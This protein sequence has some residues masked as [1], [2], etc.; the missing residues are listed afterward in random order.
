MNFSKT[1]NCHTCA[2]FS[3]EK[4]AL[5]GKVVLVESV[6]LSEQDLNE[7]YRKKPKNLKRSKSLLKFFKPLKEKV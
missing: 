2:N 5:V 4:K 6:A 7:V 1:I 3:K